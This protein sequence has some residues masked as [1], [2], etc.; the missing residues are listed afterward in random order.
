MAEVIYTAGKFAAPTVAPF[1][2]RK[3]AIR[4]VRKII[5]DITST[6]DQIE[7]ALEALVELSK[8]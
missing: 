5:R 2:P 4:A 8:E 3:E 6:D 7:D 1:D